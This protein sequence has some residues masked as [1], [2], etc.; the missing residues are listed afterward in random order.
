MAKVRVENF[1]VTV[2]GFG[3]GVGQRL[4]A[5]FGDGVDGLHDWMFAA[6][7]DKAAGKT[8]LD[9]DQVGRFAE[10][11]GATIM[12]RNMFGPMRGPW[13]DESWKGWWGDNPPYHH[14]VFV[15]THYLRPSVPMDGGT[16]FHFTDE[17]VDV[18]LERALKAADGQD[19]IVAGGASTVQQ[20]LR[21]GLIDEMHILV[22]PILAGAGE[23]LFDNVTDALGNYKVTKIASSPSAT[24]I[25][26]VRR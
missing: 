24:H 18:V 23:R 4:E 22:A 25:E 8:G 16:T 21:A 13:E 19:V 10:G 2:D 12:G 20:Y 11:V 7:K 15:H 5:P 9:A 17:P 14:D 6:Q 3:A 26:I 1:T